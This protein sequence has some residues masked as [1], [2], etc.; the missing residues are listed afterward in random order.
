[1][2]MNFG[3]DGK[4]ARVTGSAALLTMVGASTPMAA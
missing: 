3:L 1:M 4:V 2:E